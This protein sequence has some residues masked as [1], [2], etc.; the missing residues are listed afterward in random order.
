MRR[1]FLAI[2]LFFITVNVTSANNGLLP[3]LIY[4]AQTFN[5]I[6]RQ[7]TFKT[8]EREI[9]V[10]Y[11]NN[12]LIGEDHYRRLM[13]ELSV[14]EKQ[15]ANF[16]KI[17]EL[18][19]ILA[20]L[21]PKSSKP[22]AQRNNYNNG[23]LA[24]VIKNEIEE[25][26]SKKMFLSEDHYVRLKKDL[27]KLTSQGEKNLDQYYAIIE[28]SNL[29]TVHVADQQQAERLKKA[30][31]IN[32]KRGQ[33]LSCN[34]NDPKPLLMADITNVNQIGQITAPGS[35]DTPT[36]FKGHSFIWPKEGQIP[37]EGMP[38]YL[39]I[40]AYGPKKVVC[41]NENN[42]SQ[43]QLNFH[44]VINPNY[45]LRFDHLFTK[46]I[47]SKI[48]IVEKIYTAPKENPTSEE[49]EREAIEQEENKQFFNA[50]ELIG[51]GQNPIAK[52]WDFGLYNLC[53]DG[54]LAKTD[55]FGMNK[56]AVCWV[57]YYS[58]ER[59]SFYRS[60]LTGPKTVCQF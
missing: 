34:P 6:K 7:K 4:I 29:A 36:G 13:S 21:L 23:S 12:K 1:V 10:L 42:I 53:E 49:L 39:P 33:S 19:K 9:M 15:K 48:L 26:E 20:R 28:K 18:K 32:R 60:K 30:E 46:S 56:H 54:P 45:R 41:E 25:I 8:V 37:P 51:Y 47:S 27:D 5:I 55:A 24:Q 44:A 14:L 57:D 50:G 3:H 40:D 17:Q 59:A 38:V 11:K 16:K 35:P 52:N 2:L 43:C 31:E 22:S 58:P